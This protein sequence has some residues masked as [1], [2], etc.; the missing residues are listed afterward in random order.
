MSGNSVRGP[1]VVAVA[2]LLLT[3][4]YLILALRL[5]MGSPGNPG[6]GFVPLLIAGALAACTSTFLL[7][8][9]KKNLRDTDTDESAPGK[10]PSPGMLAGMALSMAAYPFLLVALKFIFSTWIICYAMMLFLKPKAFFASFLLSMVVSIAF[11]FL[12]ALI[13]GVSLPAGPVEELLYRVR[14]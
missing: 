7:S 3:L 9:L 2:L 8:F 11:Y 10:G 5:K 6:P 13:F 14:G 4:I 1:V 12:F